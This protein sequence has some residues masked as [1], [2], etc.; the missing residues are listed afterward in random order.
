MVRKL[1]GAGLLLAALAG[2]TKPDGKECSID[3]DCGA[4]GLCDLSTKLCYQGGTEP[5][6]D[7]GTCPFTCAE[8]EACTSAGCRNRFLG[9]TIQSPVD[10]AVLGGGD[11]GVV[12]VTAQLRANPSYANTTQFPEPL[13]FSATFSDGG[14]AGSID[15]GV[16]SGEMYTVPWTLPITQSQRVALTVAHPVAASGLTNTVNVTVDTLPPSFTISFSPVP[17]R[18]PGSGTQAAQGDP[19]QEYAAAF[20]RDEPVTV[21]V[22]AD[23]PASNVTLTVVGIGVGGAAGAS[24]PP[25]TLTSAGSCPGGVAFC[26]TVTVNLYEPEMRAFRGTMTFRVD[27]QD[28]V[29]N[30]TSASAGLK[31]TRWKWAF[32]GVSGT[33]KGSPAIGDKGSVYFGTTDSSGKVFAL[34]PDGSL[35]WPTAPTVG[36]VASSL[37]VGAPRTT[38]GAGE[39]VYVAAR[40]PGAGGVLYALKG[41][42]GAVALRCPSPTTDYGAG[43]VE[44]ALAL[45]A[46]VALVLPLETAVGVFN[47]APSRIVGI[48]PDAAAGSDQCITETGPGGNPI[49]AGTIGSSVL[50][51]GEDIFY[52]TSSPS[53]LTSY[54]V[55]SD[56]PR[57]N[58]PQVA[59]FPPRGM[60]LIS[61]KIYGGQGSTDNFDQGSLFSAPT[62]PPGPGNGVTNLFPTTSTSRVFN[63]AV[64]NGN[65]AYFGAENATPVGELVRLELDSGGS[66]TRVSDVGA[67]RAAPIL[68]ESDRLYTLN[69][70]GKLREW[71]ASTLAP[72]W[73]LPLGGSGVDVSPTLDCYRD[74]SGNAVSGSTLGALYVAADTKLYSFIVDSPGLAPNA[75][76]PK[77]QRNARNTGNPG[78]TSAPIVDCP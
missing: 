70:D 39:Y 57:N 11:A 50:M 10:N 5:E 68:G 20:R 54:T 73:E 26:S 66:P 16:R 40:A 60:A 19:E 14:V 24:L 3:S 28:G 36:N 9:L 31:V 55:G 71:V 42:D 63:L 41:S 8:Y 65:I 46:T 45:G 53:R 77:F 43:N 23:E 34:N 18:A 47:S 61:D 52:G 35:K 74:G 29:G 6:F 15:S 7:G 51:S 30:R 59:S 37:T 48:R 32:D 12:Q 27:G 78:L 13:L 17:I 75:P 21:T 56:T 22:L 1:L 2:C 76:W 25:V 4:E 69:A 38:G 67:L 62:A 33:I 64:G 44:G 72:Q 49:P 58:W